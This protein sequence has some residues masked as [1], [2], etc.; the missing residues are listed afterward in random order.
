MN[1]STCNSANTTNSLDV[2]VILPLLLFGLIFVFGIIGNIL[3]LFAILGR[4]EMQTPSNYFIISLT[5]SD[6]GSPLLALHSFILMEYAV[7]PVKV[8]ERKFCRSYFV[9]LKIFLF[10]SVYTHVAIALERRRVIVFPMKPKPT[11][12]TLKMS[13]VSVWIAVTAFTAPLY[14][15]LGNQ[16]FRDCGIPVCKLDLDHSSIMIIYLI[17]ILISIW[18]VPFGVLVWSYKQ[19]CYCLKQ[20]LIPTGKTQDLHLVLR[21]K[22]NKKII[23]IFTAIVTSFAVATIPGF[24]NIVLD[25]ISKVFEIS[26]ISIDQKVVMMFISHIMFFANSSNNPFIPYFMSGQYHQAFNNAFKTCFRKVLFTSNNSD[27]QTTS[28]STARCSYMH[29]PN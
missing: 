28:P 7:F 10:C 24:V 26:V 18:F 27:F 23:R 4:K 22:Q 21:F 17:C 5:V 6:L 9:F 29:S 1:Y 11:S 15:A 14:G 19:I 13:I 3:V 16:G 2:S 20:H 12:K 8:V 25:F